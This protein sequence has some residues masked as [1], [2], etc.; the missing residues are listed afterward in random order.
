MEPSSGK[1]SDEQNADPALFHFAVYRDD[2]GMW[3][4]DRGCRGPV[5]R[6]RD[7]HFSVIS[8]PGK[9]FLS[10]SGSST[11]PSRSKA[12]GETSGATSSTPSSTPPFGKWS[13]TATA[14]HPKGDSPSDASCEKPETP[15]EPF[16]RW[17]RGSFGP[18][19]FN[20]QP[21]EHL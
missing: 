14:S 18:R 8:T 21:G 5:Q 20:S 4:G 3:M 16:H 15:L 1:V 2:S 13:S 10:S 17:I 6:D 7:L 11:E 12:P 19:S 9:T